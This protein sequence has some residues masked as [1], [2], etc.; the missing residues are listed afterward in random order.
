MNSKPSMRQSQE[1]KA[2]LSV[3]RLRL[4]KAHYSKKGKVIDSDD[5]EPEQKVEEKRQAPT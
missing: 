1:G 4:N 2:L 5:E 3:A